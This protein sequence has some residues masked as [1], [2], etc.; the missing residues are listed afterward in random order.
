MN[1]FHA[2][3]FLH[4]LKLNNLKT[5]GWIATSSRVPNLMHLLD[6]DSS[7]LY[8]CFVRVF[9]DSMCQITWWGFYGSY[10]DSEFARSLFGFMPVWQG[11][12]VYSLF[13]EAWHSWN[14]ETRFYLHWLESSMRKHQRTLKLRGWFNETVFSPG[15]ISRLIEL[16]PGGHL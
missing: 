2:M 1:Y 8:A 15:Q 6:F 4:A 11:A 7:Q 14:N 16:V 9:P 13:S 10:Q 3:D 5:W 12:H